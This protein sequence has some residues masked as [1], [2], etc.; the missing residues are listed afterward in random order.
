M[1]W[2]QWKRLMQILYLKS[3][4][5]Y[6][7]LQRQTNSGGLKFPY[8]VLAKAGLNSLF[9]YYEEMYSFPQLPENDEIQVCRENYDT[10]LIIVSSKKL[11]KVSFG[12][13]FPE[14]NTGI[15]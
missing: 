12:F 14:G 10:K 3:H 8:L 6:A 7:I 5:L 4:I 13:G 1:E 15:P 11:D 9:E 2:K